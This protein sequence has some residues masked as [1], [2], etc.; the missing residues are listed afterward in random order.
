M[1]ESDQAYLTGE[2]TSYLRKWESPLK[3]CS[4]IL[5]K[6]RMFKWKY[7]LWYSKDIVAEGCVWFEMARAGV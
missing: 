7:P 4:D 6:N 3:E 2:R 1:K 5:I